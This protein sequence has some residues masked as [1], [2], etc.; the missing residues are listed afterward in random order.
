MNRSLIHDNSGMMESNSW[1]SRRSCII[2]VGLLQGGGGGGGGAGG[3]RE[4]GEGGGEG[5]REGGE[6]RG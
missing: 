3:G 2:S 1:I 6:G 4:N 5:E